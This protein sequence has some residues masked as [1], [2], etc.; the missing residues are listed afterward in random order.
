VFHFYFEVNFAASQKVLPECLERPRILETKTARHYAYALTPGALLYACDVRRPR[1]QVVLGDALSGEVALPMEGVSAGG[2]GASVCRPR[3][4]IAK[5]NFA[6]QRV[7]KCNLG[8][9]KRCKWLSHGHFP[10]PHGGEAPW[11]S[12][13]PVRQNDLRKSP[14]REKVGF[15][16]GYYKTTTAASHGKT[17]EMAMAVPPGENGWIDAL[18]TFLAERRG[19]IEELLRGATVPR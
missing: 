11:Q 3:A 13:S 10:A 4:A 5:Y 6:G 14:W 7:P 2:S 17:E 15:T 18:D 9:R 19:K 8:T 16:S 1:S 12:H